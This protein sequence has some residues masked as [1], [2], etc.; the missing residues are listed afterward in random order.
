MKVVTLPQA[1]KE[2]RLLDPKTAFNRAMLDYLIKEEKVPYGAHGVRTV[3]NFDALIDALNVIY[4]FEGEMF[5][6]SI[7]TVCNAVEEIK[8]SKEYYKMGERLI[9]RC[10][11]DGILPTITIG[12]RHYIALQSFTEPYSKKLVYGQSESRLKAEQIVNN[13]LQQMSD[14]ISERGGV[15]AVV[16][17]RTK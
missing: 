2:M 8:E 11:S 14:C 9:R 5:C 6:P 15:P 17:R 10:I 7:R 13:M 4:G 1:V 3:L 16:R 12:N